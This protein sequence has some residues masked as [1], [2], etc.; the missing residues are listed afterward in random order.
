MNTTALISGLAGLLTAAVTA[1]FA[2]RASNG[3]TRVQEIQTVMDA[4][5]DLVENL[6]SEVDRLRDQIA[7]MYLDMTRCEQRNMKMAEE[8]ATL[9]KQ[10]A[11]LERKRGTA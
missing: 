4:Y 1:W 7:V 6:R 9:K 3:T 11:Q 8:L 2:F 5:T 10:F